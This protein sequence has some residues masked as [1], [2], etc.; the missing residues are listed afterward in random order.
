MIKNSKKA[1]DDGIVKIADLICVA[2]RTAPK[3]RGI[4]NIVTTILT[5]KDKEK[6]YEK[7]ISETFKLGLQLT[8][9]GGY[10]GND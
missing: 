3:A 2:A 8:S 4:D 9:L 6:W 5:D 7:T 10:L 1:E